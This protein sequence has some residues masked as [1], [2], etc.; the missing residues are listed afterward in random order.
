MRRFLTG[1]VVAAAI[2]VVPA[3][4]LANNQQVAEEIANRL[5]NQRPNERLQDWREVSKRDGLAPRARLQPRA[6]ENGSA[7]DL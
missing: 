4:A 3:L 2:A 6:N 7:A 1:F 5:Q